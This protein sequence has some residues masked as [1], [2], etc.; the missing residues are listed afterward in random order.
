MTELLSVTDA[1]GDAAV[2]TGRGGDLDLRH[3]EQL[4]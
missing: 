2:R 3:D 1:D 4:G